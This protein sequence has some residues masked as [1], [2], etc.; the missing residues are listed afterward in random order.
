MSSLCG[1]CTEDMTKTATHPRSTEVLQAALRYASL[2][3]SVQDS[4]PWRFHVEAEHV[5]LYYDP[6][7]EVA[8]IDPLHRE[9]V[10]SCGAALFNFQIALQHSGYRPSIALVHD[11]KHPALLARVSLDGE[12][13]VDDPDGLLFDAI[14][15]RHTNREG[16]TPTRLP[17]DLQ[18]QLRHDVSVEGAWVDFVEDVYT[19]TRIAGVIRDAD[20]DQLNQEG[21]LFQLA[22]SIRANTHHSFTGTPA[23]RV[24]HDQLLA[25]EAAVLAVIGTVDDDAISWVRAGQALQ[26]ILLRCS[27]NNVWASFLNQPVEVADL[28]PRIAKIVEREGYPQILLRLGYGN[29]PLPIPTQAISEMLI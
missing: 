16:F 11:P 17:I 12:G 15:R 28:R 21:F 1:V 5:D 25:S 7:Q 18:D 9:L 19:K 4:K 14:T 24:A 10:I 27:A 13:P 22:A 29:A 6:S 23:Q 3:P 2:A 20:H 8:V 26:R